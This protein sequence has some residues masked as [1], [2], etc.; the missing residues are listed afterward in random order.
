VAQAVK[1]ACLASEPKV[2]TQVPPKE[3]KKK[4]R[5]N[6]GNHKRDSKTGRKAWRNTGNREKQQAVP[7][8]VLSFP[9]RKREA[10]DTITR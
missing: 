10:E 6:S 3:K 2:Q 5:K 4:Q 7:N 8:P 1:S 9:G